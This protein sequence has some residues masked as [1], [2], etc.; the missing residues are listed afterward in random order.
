MRQID[1]TNGLFSMDVGSGTTVVVSLP[2]N[3]RQT[4]LNR[5]QN[6]RTGDNVRLYGVFLN[7]TRV[8]LRQF[9]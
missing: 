4:D 2:S 8:E 9:Y 6:L 1:R 3:V 5:F 7:N